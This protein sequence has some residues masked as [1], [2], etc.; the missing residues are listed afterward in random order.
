MARSLILNEKR[1]LER[2]ELLYYLKVYD[3]LNHVD[4]GRM[5]DIHSMGLLLI[6]L[7]PLETDKE[8]LIALDL[9]KALLDQGL[10]PIG[11]KAKCVWQKTSETKPYLE[12]GLMFLNP[13]EEARKTIDLLIEL[14]AMPTGSFLAN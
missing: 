8:F 14:F 9:P 13:N 1:R 2:K 5:I 7:K 10:N 11:V 3:L 12:H 6:G 4:L